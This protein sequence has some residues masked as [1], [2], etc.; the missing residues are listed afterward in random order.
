[1]ETFVLLLL[2]DEWG[3]QELNVRK[4]RSS[5]PEIRNKSK[6]PMGKIRNEHSRF[7][8]SEESENARRYLWCVDDANH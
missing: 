7:D 2:D 1:M 6:S 5:K 3:F 8:H 4:T